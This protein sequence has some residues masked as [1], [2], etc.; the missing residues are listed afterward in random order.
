MQTIWPKCASRDTHSSVGQ[1]GH[2]AYRDKQIRTE[3]DRE[4]TTDKKKNRRRNG[5]R[6]RRHRD[7][8]RTRNGLRVRV[9]WWSGV[10]L[11][12]SQKVSKDRPWQEGVPGGGAKRPKDSWEISRN[13]LPKTLDTIFAEGSDFRSV[14]LD[15]STILKHAQKLAFMHPKAYL[16]DRNPKTKCVAAK[17]SP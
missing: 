7:T 11:R 14:L 16:I 10:L 1:M 9:V 12:P 8:D 17:R 5:E 15:L 6:T 13:W 2:E 4:K 3:T